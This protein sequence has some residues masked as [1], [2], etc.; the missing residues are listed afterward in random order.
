MSYKKQGI[1]TIV[2]CLNIEKSINDKLEKELSK[3]FSISKS[4]LV[5]KILKEYFLKKGD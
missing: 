1:E 3:D 5:D 4:S 2:I